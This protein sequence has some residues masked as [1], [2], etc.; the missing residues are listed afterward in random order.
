VTDRPN[1]TLRT[2]NMDCS[3]AQAM[4]GFYARL[5]A[6]EPTFTEPGW[7]LMRDPQ[8]GLGLSFQE[9]PGYVPPVWPQRPGEQSPGEQ[10]MMMHLDILVEDLE[11]ATAYAL[12]IGGRLA[13]FQPRDD[14]RILLDPSGHPFCLFLD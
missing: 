13:D 3:D 5:L 1:I 9:E 2:L 4:A 7:V 11:A 12:E 14:L 8:G 10:Q 6:W